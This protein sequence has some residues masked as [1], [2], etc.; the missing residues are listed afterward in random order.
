MAD[1]T[2]E[3]PTAPNPA[4]PDRSEPTEE[5]K[6][7]LRAAYQEGTDAPYK[8]VWIQTLGE[9]EWI[10]SERNWSTDIFPPN[11]IEHAN[12]S[13]AD[14]SRANLSGAD[15]TRATLTGANLRETNL[16]AGR[17]T[18]ATLHEAS[19]SK[20]NLSEAFLNV[21]T[22]TQAHLSEATLTGATFSGAALDRA[23][24]GGA[25]LTGAY[26]DDATLNEA[27]LRDAKLGRAYLQRAILNRADLGGATLNEA[28]LSY[29]T[30]SGADLSGATL[31]Q[32][33]LQRATVSG[34]DL[35]GAT[36]SGADLRD[37]TLS[38]SDLQGATLTAA[39]LSG[40]KLSD[41]NLSGAELS[42]ADL[43]RTQCNA[44]TTLDGITLK[45]PPI[46]LG[47]RWNG[48]P[49]DGVDWNQLQPAR[50]GDEAAIKS[51]KTRQERVEAYR[52]AARAYHGLVVVLEEQGLTIQA[53]RFRRRQRTIDRLAFRASPRT[54]GVYLFYSLLNLVSG[55]G[56]E[57]QRIFVAYALVVGMFTGLYWAASNWFTTSTKPLQWYEALVLSLSSF[58]GRG[59]FPSQIGL[60]DPLAIIASFEAVIGLFI[61][62]I[63]IATFSNRFLSK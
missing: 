4:E 58:H 23:N 25:T 46:L 51:A 50:L 6:A 56:E 19:L 63:L 52:D 9:L 59:F 44:A 16:I 11:G 55:Q 26:L 27:T 57:P 15:L 45:E 31:D 8:G 48:A 47:T 3:A 60:G 12:L 22:L 29:A 36:L 32:A 30:L 40:A 33:N 34:A 18:G 28:N 14:L 39:D 5:R 21:A 49:L 35:R 43:T 37:A 7:E 38:G 54:W 10:F 42:G 41:A 61:E 17:L 2:E 20:A 1:E 13:G 24:F 62:L 53:R